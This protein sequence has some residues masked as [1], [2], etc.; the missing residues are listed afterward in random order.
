ML[1]SY[2]SHSSI[3]QVHVE[4]LLWSSAKPP[5][6]PRSFHS[7]GDRGQGLLPSQLCLP[8]TCSIQTH[9]GLL[10]FFFKNVKNIELL[11]FW[12]H[13]VFVCCEQGLSGC[14]EVVA[15]LRLRCLGFSWQLLLSWAMDSRCMG[16][17]MQHSV[18]VTHGL[19]CSVACRILPDRG[20]NPCLLHW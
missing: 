3:K 5:F 17:G 7:R 19:G 12:S 15:T 14:C 8:G 13:W 2:I 1:K 9:G 6:C 18:A 10:S 16:F 20:P 11:F 4:H